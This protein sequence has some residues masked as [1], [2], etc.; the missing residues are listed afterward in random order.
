MSQ[1]FKNVFP[2]TSRQ[3][4]YFDY[5]NLNRKFDDIARGLK[6]LQESSTS[7]EHRLIAIEERQKYQLKRERFFID[8]FVDFVLCISLFV[9]MVVAA[10][11]IYH[12]IH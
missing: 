5:D 9:V 6:S 4:D 7:I 12:L 3:L 2:L 8:R 10:F 11:G 1:A